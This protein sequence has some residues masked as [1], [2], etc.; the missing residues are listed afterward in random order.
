MQMKNKKIASL[1]FTAIGVILLIL[2]ACGSQPQLTGDPARGGKLYDRWWVVLGAE[3][4]Q[5]GDVIGYSCWQEAVDLFFRDFV[6]AFFPYLAIAVA[7]LE[8]AF[9]RQYHEKVHI[10][11][12]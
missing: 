11:I 2:A 12:K 8:V 3:A 1:L 7:A 9:S 10:N 4:R 6:L 5:L